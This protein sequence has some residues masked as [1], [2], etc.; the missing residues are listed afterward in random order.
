MPKD[1]SLIAPTSTGL[2]TDLK[3]WM[4]PDDAYASLRNAY[5]FRGRT[6]KRFGSTYMGQGV[7]LLQQAL[8]SRLSAL[9]GT[10]NSSGNLT[11][12]IINVTPAIGQAF[13][14]A[15]TLFTVYQMGTPATMLRN[16]G[17]MTPSTYNTSSGAF[18]IMGA[19]ALTPVYFYPALPVMGFSL[20]E[21]S[22]INN[23]PA[24]AYDTRFAYTFTGGYWRQSGAAVWHGTNTNFFWVTNWDGD[25]PNDVVMYVTNFNASAGAVTATDDPIWYYDGTNWAT[26]S[27]PTAPYT[28]VTGDG[29]F[30]YT[31]RIIVVFHNRLIF[32]NTIEQTPGSPNTNAAFVNRARYSSTFSPFS[33]V[34]S[35]SDFAPD[36]WLEINQ[37]YTVG[38]ATAVGSLAGFTDASTQEAITSAEFIKDRLIVY[39]ERS[40]WELAYTD[41]QMFPFQWI[42]INT[43]LGSESPQST[44]PFDKIVLTIGSTGV[45]ACNGANVERI[46]NKIP[47]E[48][49]QINTTNQ[50]VQRVYGIRDYYVEMVY[51]S[52]PSVDENPLNVYPNRVL[53][54][55]YRNDSWAF[56]DDCITAFGYFEQQPAM[57]WQNAN[58][59]WEMANMTW[60]SG[61]LQGQAKQVIAGNQEGF[62]FYVQPD[63]SY[64]AA[65]MQV[66]N[67]VQSGTGI[68]LTIV[69]HTLEV[70]DFIYLQQG[71]GAITTIL[72]PN[73]TGVQQAIFKVES[74]GNSNTVFINPAFL[75]ATY[76]GG[77]F[78]SRVSK[79]DIVSKQWNPYVSQGRDVYL[80][81]IDFNVLKTT[82]GQVTVDYYPSYSN[83]SMLQNGTATA[84]IMGNGILEMYPYFYLDAMMVPTL[85]YPIE[86]NQT[87]FWHPIYFQTQ[88]EAVQI[89]I[90]LSDAQMMNPL[91][92]FS[93]FELQGMIL[94]TQQTSNRLQ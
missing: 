79:I 4:I 24:W 69:D 60:N 26:Y 43:E 77:A 72:I 8:G 45:H 23:Q 94:H 15:N 13:S 61:V 86:A 31:A 39:F 71:T 65:V 36:A 87:Q 92:A 21:I 53:V 6:R 75:T 12:T 84:T 93:D 46:D 42:K 58:F 63:I 19:T 22:P 82:Y 44:V 50:Q 2:Q 7:G 30:V 17:V 70:G 9:V 89:R 81:K 10:T 51:W 16:D 73:A 3:P 67:M 91:V 57:T 85:V 38:A 49:F 34:V 64:N 55:N 5:V 56:N 25:E 41:N 68:N 76:T 66:T 78:V 32:L 37:S 83:V 27:G 11:G 54:Y 62:V 1:R 47:D 20:Y 29:T 33:G 80:E 18:S 40:T 52:F 48:I 74:L 14:V 59:T 90:Y 88:G 28:V 35:G